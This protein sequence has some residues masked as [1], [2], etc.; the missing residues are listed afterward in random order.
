MPAKK[1]VKKPEGAY[2]HGNLA[3]TLKSLALKRLEESNES[4]FTIREIARDAGVSHAAAYRHFQSRRD[5]LAEI[6]KD[7]FLKITE[8]FSE[9]EAISSEDPFDRLHQIGLAY[10]SFCMNNPGYYRAMWHTDLGPISDLQELQEVGK[11]SFLKLWDTIERCKS[12]KGSDFEVRDMATASWSVVHGFSVLINE[13]LLNNPILK[14]DRSNAMDAA[15]KVLRI[16]VEGL[17]SR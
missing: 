15:E 9:A 17:R 6:S 5:L 8:S 7:G 12:A 4:D 10:I 14:I 16:L 13:S 1:K 3:E 11:N 2:H